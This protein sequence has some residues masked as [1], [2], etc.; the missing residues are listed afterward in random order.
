MINVIFGAAHSWLR[1][2]NQA[3]NDSS[4]G[5][6][7]NN[8]NSYIEVLYQLSKGLRYSNTFQMVSTA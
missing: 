3:P 8:V 2:I 1:D 7:A 6:K 4:G 5:I